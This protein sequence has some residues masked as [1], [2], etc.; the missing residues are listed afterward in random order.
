MA[1]VTARAVSGK[2][3]VMVFEG[4]YHGGTIYFGRKSA[5]INMPFPLPHRA[6]QRCGRGDAPNR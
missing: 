1:L 2:D 4:A 3:L 5:P 6:L